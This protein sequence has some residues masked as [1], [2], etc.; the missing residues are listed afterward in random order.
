MKDQLSQFV[1]DFDI[2]QDVKIIL[3]K[4]SHTIFDAPSGYIG[5]YTHHFS[6]S[7]LRLPIAPFICKV[8]DYFKV[9]ISRFNPFGMVKL[10]TFF[11]MCRAY[12]GKP[13]VNLLCSFLNLGRAGDWL[14]LS[15]RGS[16]DVLIALNPLVGTSL[17][18]LPKAVKKLR[19][20]G[21][22]KLP[23]GVGYSLPK[24]QKMAAQASKVAGEAFDPLDVDSDADIH[25]FPSAKKLKDSANY[26]WVVAHVT[27]PSWK[28]H[29]HQI[30]IKKLCDIH[31]RAYMCQVVLDNVL[32]YRT[33]ELISD[34]HKA[35]ASYDAIRARELEKDRAYAELERRCN[36]ALLD[37][38][39]NPLVADIRTEIETL[40]GHVDGLH[41]ECTRLEMDALK[42]DMASVVAKVVPDAST[43][44]IRSDEMGMLVANLVKASII[45][46]RCAAFKEVAKPKEPF[47]MEKMAGYRP[48]SKQVYDQAGDDLVNA[49]YPFLSKYVNDPYASLEQLLSK[50]PE[51]LRS[52][53]SYV[54]AKRLFIVSASWV[55]CTHD[56]LNK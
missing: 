29:L 11:V 52:K 9:H 4:R 14:T 13:T 39:I 36:E 56:I 21:K 3:P 46:G 28:E 34:L 49:S 8:L 32:N 17:P 40:Q 6:L 24:V 25:E 38:D 20:L 51:S 50:K 2:P 19:L 16:V 10:A 5:L 35:I 1:Q 54:K 43:K 18:P 37:L 12:G 27:P 26:H 30:T 31:D 22:R 15:N 7:N 41:I 44:L 53:P 42:Q 48:F 23:S 45:Y 55:A 33:Q 47:I